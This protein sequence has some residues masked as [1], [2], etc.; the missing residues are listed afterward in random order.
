[1]LYEHFMTIYCIFSYY[2]YANYIITGHLQLLFA[3]YSTYD[4]QHRSK[5]GYYYPFKIKS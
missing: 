3:V 4:F 1:M 5:T 2:N